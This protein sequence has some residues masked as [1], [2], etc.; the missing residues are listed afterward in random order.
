MDK[1]YPDVDL[2]C[3]PTDSRSFLY[4]QHLFMEMATEPHFP[5][6]LPR[7]LALLVKH[8][9]GREPQISFT[10]VVASS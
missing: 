3:K 2:L 8:A 7:G 4:G 10:G 1:T 5:D 9:S 6:T